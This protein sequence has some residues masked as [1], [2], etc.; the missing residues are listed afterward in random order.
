MLERNESFRELSVTERVV[1][2]RDFLVGCWPQID[3][4]MGKHDWDI[5]GGQIF[6]DWVETCWQL[7]VGREVLGERKGR[8]TK[9]AIYLPQ[10]HTTNEPLYT[11][12]ARSKNEKPLICL[13]DKQKI[14]EQKEL[15]VAE[16]ITTQDNGGFGFY[17]PFDVVTLSTGKRP[18][19]KF[20]EVD[21]NQLEF[22]LKEL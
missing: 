11:I 16:F 9:L 1:L 20:Y 6:D 5:D 15:R 10:N 19:V 12:L 17:P 4:L 13:R 22:Y 3:N 2:F 7:F 21:F 18:K 8:L 14:P